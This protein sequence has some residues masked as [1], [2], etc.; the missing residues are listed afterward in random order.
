MYKRVFSFLTPPVR[1]LV[2]VLVF[3]NLLVFALT[4]VFL[5]YSHRLYQE[6]AEITVRNLNRLLSQSIAGDI[7]RIDLG[8]KA[9]ADEYTRQR[10]LGPIDQ[11][12]IADFLRRQKER[13]PMLDSLRI[14]N[15]HG[16]TVHGADRALP[17][18][19]FIA[20][21]DY[22]AALRA[23]PDLGLV[24][25]QPVKGKISGKWVLIFARALR[26]P[27]GRFDGVGYAPVTMEWFE[28]QLAAI[29]TGPHGVAVLR[30][31]ASRNFDVLARSPSGDLVGQAKVSER[32]RSMIA[33]HPAG[34]NYVAPAGGD[35]VTRFFSY[36]SISSYPLITLVGFATDD[37]FADWWR[38]VFKLVGLALAFSLM[39]GFGALTVVRAWRA[40]TEADE[41]FRLLL[42]SAGAGIFGVDT[43]GICTFC[44]PSATQL[45]G[46]VAEGAL[47]GQ[48]MHQR[49][50]QNTSQVLTAIS[51]GGNGVHVDDEN[52]LRADGTS[53]PVEY[54]S[55]PQRKGQRVIGAV[56][57]FSDISVRRQTESE[58]QA[59]ETNFRILAA[60]KEAVLDNVLVGIAV[61][62]DQTFIS[63]NR[64]MEEI[65]SC[66]ADAL[67]GTSLSTLFDGPDTFEAI[68]QRAD[69]A[70]RT[71][72]HFSAT[73]QMVRPDGAL[74]WADL[75]GRAVDPQHPQDSSVWLFSDVSE[76]K[77]A[78]EKVLFLAL[79]DALTGLPNRA[80][81]LDRFQLAEAYALR[82]NTRIAL[83]YLDLDNF[84]SINDSLGHQVGDLL[85]KEV[86]T[87]IAKCVRDTD[88]ISRQGGDEFLI[89]LSNIASPDDVTPVLTQ[90]LSQV[91]APFGYEG[92]E[93]ITSVSIGI[94]IFPDDGNNFSTLAKMADLAMYQAK[95]AGRNTYRF[96]DAQMNT[97]AV[98]H[99]TVRNGLR[100]ALEKN[101]FVLHYQPQI[102]MATG[103]VIGVE[104]LIRW[105][106]PELGLLAPARFIAVAEDSGLIVPMGEWVLHEAC[107]QGVL[108]KNAGLPALVIAVNLSAVQF[109]RGDKSIEQT[110]LGALEQS[111]LDPAC[112]ELEITESILIQNVESVLA[113][114]KRLKRLGIKLSIDDFGTGY[115]SL[116]YLKR[117]DV[118]K[119]KIDRS[120]INDLTTDPNDAAIVH[121]IIQMGHSL[122]LKIIAEGVE[123]CETVE[124]L[125][126]L[127]CDEMQGYFFARPMPANELAAYLSS[128]MG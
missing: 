33:A 116:A 117:F 127:H 43:R 85:L 101:E 61:L 32:F 67:M 13:L 11:R 108:W 81:A 2:T 5:E 7:E 38:E 77:Q 95:A 78:E 44:N 39:S 102:E 65:F 21:R 83:L 110:I 46:Y 12:T 4:G 97:E 89:I 59:S 37:V 20:D 84:K 1:R 98:E 111:G 24:L 48:D 6:R 125:R 96:Y 122:N 16:E 118:D 112:L 72:H 69:Q 105:Q 3:V 68:W 52:F 19:I 128:R 31:N 22:F 91:A 76:R 107:H 27:D 14:A 51:Q 92:L 54:W 115:S 99:L 64:R 94:A 100:R 71:G 25:S 56:V 73:L 126:A 41:Q 26:L 109:R 75:S 124:Q 63:C 45:L 88:T 119:L 93:L 57:T 74:F 34:G 35:N 30:G 66:A 36:Q 86:S 113:T 50:L 80:R 70:F 8:L 120:F 55:Y 18:G 60:E 121:A 87:R 23:N 79:H 47:L 123:N 17:A 15:A 82:S 53:F 104:A 58:L 42:N 49:V 106:H 28:K 9:M 103:A 62:R 29:E 10:S 114:V 40:R 90:L